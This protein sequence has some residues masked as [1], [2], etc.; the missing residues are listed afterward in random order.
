MNPKFLLKT[1]HDHGP[2]EQKAIRPTDFTQVLKVW[3][4][5][6]LEGKPSDH[7]IVSKIMYVQ[8]SF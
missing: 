7:I 8:K 3:A 6:F 1:P 4:K 5:I 2:V